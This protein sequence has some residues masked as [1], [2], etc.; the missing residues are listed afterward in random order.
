MKKKLNQRK[1]KL[2]KQNKR[3]FVIGLV[4]LLLV[5][6]GLIVTE[7]INDEK[8]EVT[9]ITASFHNTPGISYQVYYR[10]NALNNDTIQ[11]EDL[12]YFSAFIDHIKVTFEDKYQGMSDAEYKGDYTLL[13]EITGWEIGTEVPAPAWTKKFVISPKKN[14][15]TTDDKL[16]LSTSANID[17]NHYNTFV[18]EIREL[19]GYN[20]NYSMKIT[21]ALDYTITTVDGDVAGSLHPSLIIPLEEN[22]FKI[23]KAD[24]EEK[25]NDITKTAEVA[26]PLNYTK[27]SLFSAISFLCLIL[28][29]L[30]VS[31]VEPTLP[32][33]QRKRVRKLLKTYGNR[34]AAIEKDLSYRNTEVCNVHSMGDLV[35]ISDEIECPIF[36]EYKKDPAEI[37]E[38]FIIDREKAYIYQL[39]DFA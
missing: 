37:R 18:S 15:C 13:G 4:V 7:V 24:V 3:Y 1:L 5:S 34:I 28:L 31:S 23:V 12:G 11:A 33:I 39:I 10:Q 21:M 20:T 16:T 25:K 22:Y 19:T 32:D 9:Q 17:Y 30:I 6:I 26:V 8:I 38:F 29:L 35:K 2:T 27:I 14:F 36:Y